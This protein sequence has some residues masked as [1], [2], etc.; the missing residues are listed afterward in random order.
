MITTLRNYTPHAV[1]FYNGDGTIRAVYQS[2][3]CARCKSAE[4]NVGFAAGI[5]VCRMDFGEI[6]GLPATCADNEG[7][8]VSA[9]TAQAAKALNHPLA[10]QGRLF[11]TAHPVRNPDGQI[12]GCYGLARI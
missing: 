7:F 4:S 9:I 2:V 6:S 5:P 12:V 3:G 1:T 11:V 8:I 10:V